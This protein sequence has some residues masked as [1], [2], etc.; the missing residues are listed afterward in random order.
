M[1]QDGRDA[2][3]T[4]SYDDI[5]QN[6]AREEKIRER[7]MRRRMGEGMCICIP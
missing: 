3:L 1:G 2:V 7:R 4:P 5:R 6:S